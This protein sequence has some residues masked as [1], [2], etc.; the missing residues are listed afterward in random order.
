MSAPFKRGDIVE[1]DSSAPFKRGDIVEYDSSSLTIMRHP[2][3]GTIAIL[4]DRCI[5]GWNVNLI[6]HPPLDEWEF[7]A[8]LRHPYF[9]DGNF[10][11]L[12]E[13]SDD[14]TP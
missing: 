6:S 8:W 11:K 13:T 14:S 12:T 4:G 9:N 2:L 10:R 3:D 5:S 7:R 1:Y